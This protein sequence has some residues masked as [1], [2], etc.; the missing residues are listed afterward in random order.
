[1]P[2]PPPSIPCTQAHR[3]AGRAVVVAHAAVVRLRDATRR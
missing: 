3:G 1:V 2:E